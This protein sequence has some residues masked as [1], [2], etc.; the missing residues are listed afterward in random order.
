MH[1]VKKVFFF[2]FLI[3]IVIFGV[4]LKLA[5]TRKVEKRF[6]DCVRAF[7][8]EVKHQKMKYLRGFHQFSFCGRKDY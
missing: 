6:T 3:A 1:T 7:S 2:S 5:V 4:H 8:M